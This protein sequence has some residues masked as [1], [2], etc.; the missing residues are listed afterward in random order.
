VYLQVLKEKI[1]CIEITGVFDSAGQPVVVQVS[2]N[3]AGHGRTSIAVNCPKSIKLRRIATNVSVN[4]Q[5][6]RND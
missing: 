5:G 3:K 6:Q 4:N 2:V 1:E